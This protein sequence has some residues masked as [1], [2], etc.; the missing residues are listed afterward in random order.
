MNIALSYWL[1]T[2]VD[3]GLLQS[4]LPRLLTRGVELCTTPKAMSSGS[5]AAINTKGFLLV[6]SGIRYLNFRGGRGL[7]NDRTLFEYPS[8]RH[9]YDF[10]TQNKKVFKE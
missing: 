3:G 5:T 6:A 4:I 2:A 10:T 9:T 7:E 1:E 8:L